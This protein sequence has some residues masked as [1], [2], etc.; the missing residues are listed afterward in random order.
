MSVVG[1]DLGTLNTVIAVARNR[2]VD[3]VVL[4]VI[5]SVARIDDRSRVQSR[6]QYAWCKIGGRIE[7]VVAECV[8]TDAERPRVDVEDLV[9]NV[10]QW[11]D[12]V[13][14]DH[15]RSGILRG[16]SY[17]KPQG[18]SWY[19]PQAYPLNQHGKYLLMAPGRDRAGTLGFRCVVDAK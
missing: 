1:C 17:Y 14:D 11:T 10:W 4:V 8:S 12:E 6:R 15:T 2:G 13:M 5:Q 16:G 19:F 7:D 9:G 18:S 3:V